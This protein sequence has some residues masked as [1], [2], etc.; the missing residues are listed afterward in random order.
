M[1]TTINGSPSFAYLAVELSPGDSVIAE[2]DAMATMAAELDMKAHFN[3]GFFQVFVKSCL[4]VSRFLLTN[5][6]TTVAV[7]SP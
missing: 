1:K 7:H 2:S 3:G 5:F 4:E 6:P